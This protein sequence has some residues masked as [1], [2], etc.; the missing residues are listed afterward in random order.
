MFDADRP[1][2]RTDQDKLDRSL[3]AKYL[4]RC[5]LDHKDPESLVVGLYGG[6]GVGKTSLINLVLEEL[7][8]AA[9]NVEDD[10]K[11]IILNFS[12]WSYSGENQLVYSF[13]RRL[14]SV[15]RSVPYLENADRIIYLMELYVSFFTHKPVPKGL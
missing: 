11:P 10:E 6:W 12:A 1:I 8:F 5:M 14:S 7:N 4:A 9:S 3:F 15:L 2:T 13:F